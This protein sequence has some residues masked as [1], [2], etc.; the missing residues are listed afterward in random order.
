MDTFAAGVLLREVARLHM[1]LQREDV[2]R[3][4]NTTS[5][6]CIIL[7]ELGR[8]GEMTL[9]DLGR[10]AGLDKGWVSRTV[11][12]LAQEG[13]VHKVPSQTDRRTIHVSLSPAGEGRY[14]TLNRTLNAQAERVI[15]HIPVAER[16]CVFHALQLL[17]E[18]LQSERQ[19]ILETMTE[20][21]VG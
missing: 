17:R 4:D 14:H 11:E 12:G 18:A 2:S 6:Q 13:L 20:G 15:S 10:R 21:G 1:Q 19:A 7:T 5:T 16:D 8:N 9:A 3:C